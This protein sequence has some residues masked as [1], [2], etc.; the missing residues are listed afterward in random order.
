MSSVINQIQTGILPLVNVYKWHSFM[1]DAG[2]S[3]LRRNSYSRCGF[4]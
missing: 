1:E 4:L 2:W 3:F